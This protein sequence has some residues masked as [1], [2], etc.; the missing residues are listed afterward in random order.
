MDFDVLELEC[1]L[2]QRFMHLS[3]LLS[4]FVFE[5]FGIGVHEDLSDSSG[6]D[7]VLVDES[8]RLNCIRCYHFKVCIT[9]FEVVE[10]FDEGH[11]ES[12]SVKLRCEDFNGI[13]HHFGIAED[14][15]FGVASE[16]KGKVL[17]LIAR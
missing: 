1:V 8:K 10:A 15:L 9:A 7:V 3:A 11:R 13:H 6:R 14:S 5:A 2:K 12:V 16:E 17:A 4:F